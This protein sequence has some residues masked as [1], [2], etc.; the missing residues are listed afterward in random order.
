MQTETYTLPTHWAPYLI[1]GDASGLENAEEAEIDG[2]LDA[3]PHLGSCLSCSDEPEFKHSHD[4]GI[5]A[6]D[7]LDFE[8]ALVDDNREY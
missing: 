1:N 4:G 7:C 3:H 2:W 8:F 6:A 5:L